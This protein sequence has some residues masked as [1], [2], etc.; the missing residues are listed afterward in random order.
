MRVYPTKTGKY[1]DCPVCKKVSY[2]F[3][4][5]IKKGYKAYCSK[6]CWYSV[7]PDRLRTDKT[8]KEGVLKGLKNGK[9]ARIK[10]IKSAAVRTK[11]SK[12]HKEAWASGRYK[13]RLGADNKL[14]KGGVAALQNKARQTP[15]YKIWRKAIYEYDQYKCVV[16]DTNNDLH[17]HHVLSFADYP[18]LRYDTDNGVTLCRLCHSD[19]HGRNLPD[20]SNVN[21]R[22]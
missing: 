15:E 7:L 13:K 9:D 19:Y 22:K 18:D 11:M 4:S 20:I 8:Y 21:K 5:Q 1:V 2:R 3:P 12:S 16:C 17:A 14:W 6:K 10:A